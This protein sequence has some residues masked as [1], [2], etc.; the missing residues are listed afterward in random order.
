MKMT[1]ANILTLSRLFAVPPFIYL[2]VMEY[3][4]AALIVFIVA[5]FT[6]LIDGTVARMLKQPS[7]EGAIIDPIADKLLLESSFIALTVAGIVPIW[8]LLLAFGRD[9]M[10]ISGICYLKKV[11]AAL[12]YRA[13]WISKI[14][15]LFQLGV[16]VI[17]LVRWW[18]PHSYGMSE[19][20]L[21]FHIWLLLVT[22]A[23]IIISGIRYL[24]MGQKLLR[25]K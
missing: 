23:L 22:A 10:I 19:S 14:A 11:K 9:L 21:R 8:F 12:P 20:L 2:F 24:Y 6:D 7:D 5:G 16:S 15:T 3:R 1:A 4:L 18:M 17:G 13:A 25:V